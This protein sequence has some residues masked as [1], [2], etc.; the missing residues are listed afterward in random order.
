MISPRMEEFKTILNQLN[1]PL[2]KEVVEI[3]KK[4]KLKS[5]KGI[6]CE[7]LCVGV[8]K[9][10]RGKGIANALTQLLL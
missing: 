1:E 2:K 8:H 3:V 5:Q 10:F 7:M 6:I 4:Y 9:D